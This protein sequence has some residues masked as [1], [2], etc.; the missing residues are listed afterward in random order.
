MESTYSQF[1]STKGNN[2]GL[3][4]AKLDNQNGGASTLKD[5]VLRLIWPPGCL[6][7]L[8]VAEGLQWLHA[9]NAGSLRMHLLPAAA[10]EAPACAAA[11][12]VLGWSAAAS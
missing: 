6:I 12:L 2:N 1:E 11:F 4:Y 10:D 8:T 9:C 7:R 5:K 3:E